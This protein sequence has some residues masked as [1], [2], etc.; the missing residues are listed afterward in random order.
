MYILFSVQ[1]TLFFIL[2]YLIFKNISHSKTKIDKYEKAV[3][4]SVFIIITILFL[5]EQFDKTWFQEMAI[6]KALT[7]DNNEAFFIFTNPRGSLTPIF[8]FYMF[9]LFG[10]QPLLVYLLLITFAFL[11]VLVIYKLYVLLFNKTYFGFFAVAAYLFIGAFS[12]F[13]G[14]KSHEV[15][16]LFWISLSI[17]LM[18]LSYKMNKL[19]SYLLVFLSI[20]LTIETRFETIFLVLLFFIGL[21][22]F[23]GKDIFKFKNLWLKKLVPSFIIFLLFLPTIMI[24]YYDHYIFTPM[25]GGNE[26]YD[27][28]VIKKLI[29]TDLYEIFK[30]TISLIPH[31][32]INLE[33]LLIFL[34]SFYKFWLEVPYIYFIPFFL[35]GLIFGLLKFKKETI[36]L[37]IFFVIYSYIFLKVGNGY[38]PRYALRTIVPFLL[39]CTLG[40]HY[41][42]VNGEKFI[43][44]IKSKAKKLFV[45][46][47]I[48]SCIIFFFILMILNSFTLHWF[49]V[50]NEISWSDISLLEKVNNKINRTDAV[51]LTTFSECSDDEYKIEYVTQVN[52]VDFKKFLDMA[53]EHGFPINSVYYFKRENMSEL[54]G[55][56]FCC[57]FNL[58]DLREYLFK[59]GRER[60]LRLLETNKTLRDRV[61][62]YVFKNNTYF[63]TKTACNSDYILQGLKR[64]Y[65]V[66]T[67]FSDDLGYTVYKVEN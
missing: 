35:L 49:S 23:R 45:K 20:L 63:I 48:I 18:I 9:M 62:N 10:F 13:W 34:Y 54:I 61:A 46:Y 38:Q 37:V 8:F 60:S 47:F 5:N 41:I 11:T 39:L 26:I 4:L 27:G 57:Y 29:Q 59:K 21:I 32:N 65:N 53:E 2:L 15:L 56:K 44:Y 67:I 43:P 6:G 31:E 28:S 33:N 17:L 16:V 55:G 66:S 1:L 25:I 36:F 30:Q 19:I 42:Y 51:I 40:F 22:V 14:Y 50:L 64:I 24:R 3:F 52:T 58:E 12:L 7:I